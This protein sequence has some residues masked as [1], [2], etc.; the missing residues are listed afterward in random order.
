MAPNALALDATT[1]QAL[2][3]HWAEMA[4]MEHASVAAFSR[5]VLELLSLGAPSELVFDAQRALGDEI[6][7]AELCFGLAS[8]YAGTRVAPGPLSLDGAL[9][10][11]SR[12]Q[13]GLNAFLEACLGEAQ[14]VAEAR[15]AL[16]QSRDP[17]VRRVLSR[18]VGDEARH[19]ELGFR[20]VQWLLENVPAAERAELSA[21]IAQAIDV[22]LMAESS[23][24]CGVHAPEHGL[25]S[26]SERAKARRSALLEVCI[27]CVSALLHT[28][29]AA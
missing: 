1:R 29:A 14:A 20:F 10:P 5:F 21:G 23:F 2:A 26:Q 15:S 6:A 4:L 3:A 22:A 7:H 25:L 11:R 18:I 17:E 12:V 9:A 16:E 27:P 8:A 24:S 28:R 19:A 13:I